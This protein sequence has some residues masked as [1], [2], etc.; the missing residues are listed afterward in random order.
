M[1]GRDIPVT[2]TGKESV[3]PA[4]KKAGDALERLG[5]KAEEAARDSKKLD[6]EIEDLNRSLAGLAA[7]YAAAGTAEERADLGKSI[8][9]Q[10]SSLRQLTNIK[11]LMESAGKDGADGFSVGFVARLGPL[12]A[13]APLSP[14]IAGAIAAGAPIIASAVG[15]AV[16]LGVA[17]AA[18]GAGLAVAFKDPTVKAAGK[19]LGTQVGQQLTAAAQ[20]FVPETLKGIGYIKR[21]LASLQP[22][23]QDIFA[24]AAAYVQPFARGIGGLVRELAPGLRDAVRNAEPLIDLVEEH[25]PEMGRTLGDAMERMSRNAENAKTT[26]DAT[27]TTLE[28]MVTVT[29]KVVEMLSTDVAQGI[30]DPLGLQ[31]LMAGSDGTV[32]VLKD[33]KGGFNDT[34]DAASDAA[35]DVRGYLTALREATDVNL[36]SRASQRDLEQAI[37]DASETIKENGKTLDINTQKGRE[38][39]A[40]LDQIRAKAYG[41]AEGILAAGGSQDQA[42]QALERGRRAFVN[43]AVAAGMERK[44]A[45]RLAAQLFAIPNVNRTVTVNGQKALATAKAIRDVVNGLRN[46]NITI[47]VYYVTRG[48]NAG[49]LKVPGGTLTK[50]RWGGMHIPMAAGGIT[51]AG[52]YPASNPPLISFAEPATGGEA[53]IPRKGNAARSTQILSK[54]AGWYGMDVVPRGAMSAGGGVMLANYG[55]IGSRLDLMNWLT[56]ALDELRRRGRL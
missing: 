4:A 40:A 15:G 5:D 23:L 50:D 19:E 13:R 43:A 21:E 6:N 16:T 34:G 25:L 53:Y 24:D 11:K 2:L 38:N 48:R 29:S 8:R 44:E 27:L 20:P 36:Q 39:Q 47:G 52:I 14:P 17:S 12:L 46:K 31:Q 18:V 7:A 37:D 35:T 42:N 33:I 9:K 1:A 3:S 26:L 28:G 32:R 55:V 54:A 51:S 41:A 45:E 56:N 30:A 49:D 22:E 10:Q